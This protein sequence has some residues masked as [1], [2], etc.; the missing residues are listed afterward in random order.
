MAAT[1]REANSNSAPNDTGTDIR[2][3]RAGG[4]IG[5]IGSID[6]L[7]EVL[8]LAATRRGVRQA[9]FSFG[10]RRNRLLLSRSIMVQFRPTL[11]VL[12]KTTVF[13]VYHAIHVLDDAGI[14]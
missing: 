2:Q 5:R 12:P 1:T 8:C 11:V 14:M 6:H 13:H 3:C 10:A 9:A 4:E 7:R